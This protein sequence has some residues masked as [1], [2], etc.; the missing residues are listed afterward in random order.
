M[1]DVIGDMNKRRGRI[2]G[3]N[4]KAGGIQEIIAEAPMA[5]MQRY[6]ID[7]R[8]LSQAY[9]SYRTE[10]A[11]YEEVPDQIAK[12]IIEEAAVRMKVDGE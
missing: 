10:F 11:R 12:K 4:P 6:A 8:A 1:G 9:G 2:L 5:E 7:L 3:M